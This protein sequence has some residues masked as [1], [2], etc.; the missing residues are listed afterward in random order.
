M[1]SSIIIFKSDFGCYI[2]LR[3]PKA[4]FIIELI[5]AYCTLSAQ[6][7][8]RFDTPLEARQLVSRVKVLWWLYWPLLDIH[9][10]Y[11]RSITAEYGRVI[12]FSIQLDYEHIFVTDI[13]NVKSAAPM[14]ESKADTLS[15]SQQPPW[16]WLTFSRCHRSISL[17]ARDTRAVE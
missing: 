5:R 8:A 10:L 17:S 1:F 14:I 12:S 3:L 9:I 15:K 4:L 2:M 13:R 16:L 6:V 7:T 11:H